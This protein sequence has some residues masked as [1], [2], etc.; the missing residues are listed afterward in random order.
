M[1]SG[2]SDEIPEADA[3][4]ANLE[5]GLRRQNPD[6]LFDIIQYAEALISYLNDD[7]ERKELERDKDQ[8]LEATARGEWTE[9]RRMI[10]CGKEACTTCPHG[11][12]LY[13][14]RRASKEKVEWKYIG[15]VERVDRRARKLGL[16]E[17]GDDRIREPGETGQDTPDEE[18]ESP[19]SEVMWYDPPP[20]PGLQLV[21]GQVIQVRHSETNELNRATV[22]WA[23]EFDA[24]GDQWLASCELDTGRYVDVGPAGDY[25]IESVSEQLRGGRPDPGEVGLAEVIG[26]IPVHAGE[27]DDPRLEAFRRAARHHA[28][29]FVPESPG[30]ASLA[31][32]GRVLLG[33]GDATLVTA[34]DSNLTRATYAVGNLMQVESHARQLM[35]LTLDAYEYRVG[36]AGQSRSKKYTDSDSFDPIPEGERSGHHLTR[37]GTPDATPAPIREYAEAANDAFDQVHDRAIDAETSVREQAPTTAFACT[38]AAELASDF[39]RVMQAPIIP[40]TTDWFTEYPALTEA[41]LNLCT[42]T[43]PVA[44]L[45]SHLRRESDGPLGGQDSGGDE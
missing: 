20:R 13:L 31:H 36:A 35:H 6:A 10:R 32:L 11:P 42:P 5:R 14:A 30:K 21:D 25:Q 41:Y 17:P 16:M 24:D 38:N 40:P 19:T 28:E 34:T 37:S 7:P 8:Y 43:E 39:H 4:P 12:Y 29:S 9:V 1:S 23:A 33:D 15:P 18:S 3:L 44:E 2:T 22:N 27:E 26:A 45:I